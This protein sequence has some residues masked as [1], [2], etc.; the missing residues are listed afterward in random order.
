[1]HCGHSTQRR[2]SLLVPNEAAAFPWSPRTAEALGW[3]PVLASGWG[4]ITEPAKWLATSL[5]TRE[6]A[7][8]D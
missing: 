1:M 2:H 6:T 8:S 3:K 7:T 4:R 5:E